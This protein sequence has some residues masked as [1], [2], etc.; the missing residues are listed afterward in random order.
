MSQN[1]K[2]LGDWS[3]Y[4]EENYNNAGCCPYMLCNAMEVPPHEVGNWLTKQGY[5]I[6][7]NGTSWY[8]T[9]PALRAFGHD[10]EQ[11]NYSPMMN[12]YKSP[13]FDRWKANTKAGYIGLFCMGVGKNTYWTRGGH[14][15]CID[16]YDPVRDMY[17]VVD[18]A[19]YDRDGWHSFDIGED[20]FVGNIKIA[21]TT[22][23]YMDDIPTSAYAYE[24]SM[25]VLQRGSKGKEV[26]LMQM[27]WQSLGWYKGGLDGDYGQLTEDACRLAQKFGRITV[28]GICGNATQ[29]A[30][31]KLAYQGN[32]FF[33]KYVK[34]GDKGDTVTFYQCLLKARG[35]YSGV[36]DGDFGNGTR[37]AVKAFQSALSLKTDGEIGHDTGKALVGF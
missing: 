25:P 24:F 18:S 37:S 12:V 3:P 15:I 10:G 6:P 31:F 26:L 33:L 16:G 28:D 30:T 27:V 17:H 29:R 4:A 22:N 35:Y 13:V 20:S 32:R 19:S 8:A 34:K 23:I 9:P 2:Q 11:L 21:Y 5:A 7:M 36:I 1:L 14:Y